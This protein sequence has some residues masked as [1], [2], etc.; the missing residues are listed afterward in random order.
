MSRWPAVPPPWSWLF[1]DSLPRIVFFLTLIPIYQ[2][3]RLLGSLPFSTRE[4]LYG[5]YWFSFR[6]LFFNHHACRAGC[7][8]PSFSDHMVHRKPRPIAC[9]IARPQSC[10][11]NIPCRAGAGIR[12][13]SSRQPPDDISGGLKHDVEGIFRRRKLYKGFLMTPS[14]RWGN[15]F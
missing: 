13:A 8:F 3:V 12:T 15:L 11:P 10:C 2:L 5:C 14:A 7:W 6:F 1:V 9:Y 4:F